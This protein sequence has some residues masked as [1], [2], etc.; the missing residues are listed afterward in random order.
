MK[1]YKYNKEGSSFTFKIVKE[2]NNKL[3]VLT[4]DPVTL[5]VIKASELNDPKVEEI[6]GKL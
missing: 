6:K 3:V 1:R 4:E 2:Y 5:Q